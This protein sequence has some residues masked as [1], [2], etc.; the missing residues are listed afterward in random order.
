MLFAQTHVTLVKNR[1]AEYTYSFYQVDEKVIHSCPNAL[2]SCNMV[3]RKGQRTPRSFFRRDCCSGYTCFRAQ[4]VFPPSN[5]VPILIYP[6]HSLAP[7][8]HPAAMCFDKISIPPRTT[9][10]ARGRVSRI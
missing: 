6:G 9:G 4:I 7:N 10:M 2:R 8:S 5:G 1:L 3:V